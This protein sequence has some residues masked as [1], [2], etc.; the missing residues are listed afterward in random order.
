MRGTAGVAIATSGP[1]ATNLVTGIANAYF[2]SVPCVFLTGQVSTHLMRRSPAIRQEGFQETDIV[3]IVKPITKFAETVTDPLR[4]RFTLE[5]AFFL[6][7]SGRPGS[8]LIDLPHNVQRADIEPE[9]LSGFFGSE[10][11]RCC[12]RELAQTTPGDVIRRVVEMLGDARRPVVLAGGGTASVRG[13]GALESFLERCD[14]PLVASLRG[15]DCIDHDNPYF[16]GFIGSWGNRYANFAVAK[17]DLLVVLGSRLDERQVGSDP[18]LFASGAKVVHVDIDPPVLNHVLAESVSIHGDVRAFLDAALRELGARRLRHDKWL[19]RI[20]SWKQDYPSS[21]HRPDVPEVDPS[22]LLHRLSGRL[23]DGAIVC[24][25]VGQNQ[26][27]AAQSWRLSRGQRLLSSSGHGAMGYS[28]PAGIGAH[29]AAPG[30]QIVCVMGDGGIQINIQ[31]L[32]TVTRDRIPLKIVLLNNRSLGMIRDFHE[33]FFDNRCYGSVLGFSNPDFEKLASAYGIGYTRIGGS[34]EFDALEAG[35][36][37]SGP[38]LFE[39]LVSPT[40]TVEPG[41]AP[42]RPV[43]D[44]LPLLG[45]EELARALSD[46]TDP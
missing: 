18:R 35:L 24:L 38:H 10:E 39:V 42:M 3:S 26:M 32:Q 19:T 28:L 22:E 1:G 30:R 31:E 44:Q 27:W 7:E 4:I 45:R 14:V 33:R 25:D 43:A 20:R 34:D 37:T 36:H 41:P 29:Y 23:P 12:E 15:L 17:S 46:D 2:D 5:K 21:A 8:V 6:A 13:S 11:H 9:L 40:T 16:S